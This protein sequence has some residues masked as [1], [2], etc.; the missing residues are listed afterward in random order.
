MQ[1]QQW[2]GKSFKPAVCTLKI[3]P[4][5]KLTCNKRRW[6]R[7]TSDT[8]EVYIQQR[9]EKGNREDLVRMQKKGEGRRFA[10]ALTHWRLA[11]QSH[12]LY[13]HRLP[14]FKSRHVLLQSLMAAFSLRYK[15]F[16]LPEQK[17]SFFMGKAIVDAGNWLRLT[18]KGLTWQH[19]FALSGFL[20]PYSV[21]K[22]VRVE[23]VLSSLKMELSSLLLHRRYHRLLLS[24]SNSWD[25]ARV[26]TKIWSPEV[27]VL[28]CT[29]KQGWYFV[30]FL[31]SEFLVMNQ[32]HYREGKGHLA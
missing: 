26:P 24:C 23:Y 12:A 5:P 16:A 2:A 11:L 25:T 27:K 4:Q 15:M 22:E 18:A 17:M 21:A 31:Q 10:D 1:V 19:S 28:I 29:W 7:A 30:I 9:K 20:D 13:Q 3:L 14:Q 6:R 8:S 32:K